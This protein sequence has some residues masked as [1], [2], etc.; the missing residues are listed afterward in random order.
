MG[1]GDEQV[2]RGKGFKY[3]DSSSSVLSGEE[4]DYGSSGDA[5]GLGRLG[6]VSGSFEFLSFVVSGVPGVG[7]IADFLS[8]GSSVGCN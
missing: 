8:S 1:S 2:T 4:D 3:D 6:L 7:S 5:S